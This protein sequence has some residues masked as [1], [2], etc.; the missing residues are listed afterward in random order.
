[1]KYKQCIFHGKITQANLVSSWNN[2]SFSHRFKENKDGE[3]E[4]SKIPSKYQLMV[5]L[6][7]LISDNAEHIISC[8]TVFIHTG[9][10]SLEKRCLIFQAK[11]SN[12]T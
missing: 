3:R 7:I 10:Q 4:G 9:Q 8:P 12:R 11:L 1:M 5:V 2:Y 6:L